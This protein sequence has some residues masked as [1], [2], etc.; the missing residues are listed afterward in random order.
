MIATCIAL[1]KSELLA[2]NPGC[3]RDVLRGLPPRQRPGR[4]SAQAGPRGPDGAALPAADAGRGEPKRWHAAILR[5]HQR[6]F[7]AEIAAVPR[8][9]RLA[10]RLG[11]SEEH[12]SEL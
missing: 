7:G 10:A 5:R 11:R 12:T 3:R 8:S 4:R 6:L 1:G 9:A 2:I